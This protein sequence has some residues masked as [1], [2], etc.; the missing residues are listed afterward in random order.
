ME[1][2]VVIVG[3]LLIATPILA[4]FAFVRLQHLAEQ[5]ERA[6]LRELVARV[7]ALEQRLAALQHLAPAA[8]G[9]T[10]PAAPS[11]ATPGVPVTP[12]PPTPERPAVIPSPPPPPPTPPSNAAQE[13]PKP[14]D[15]AHPISL[16][17]AN[18]LPPS[19]PPSGKAPSLDLESLIAGRWFNR[20]GILTLIIAVSFFLKYA[21]DNNWIGS[22]GRVAIGVLLGAAM[23][24]WSHWLFGKGYSYFSE[25][26]AALGQATLLLSI[27]AGCRYYTLFS[28]NVGFAGMIVVTAIMAA[29]A[30]GRNSQRIA[31]LSLLGGFLTPL[32]LSTG[33][34]EETTLFTYLLI[35]GAGLLIIAMRRDWRSLAPV[36]FIFT[37]IYF[38]GWYETY[39]RTDALERTIVFS[40]LFFLLYLAVPVLRAIRT[41]SLDSISVFVVL[42]NSFAYLGALYAMLWPQDRWPLTLV[43]LAL[44][45]GHVA[46]A[47]FA[48]SPR[49]GEWPMTRQL[50]AG[51]A[52]TF[53]TLAIPI[54]L[55]GKW[56]TLALAVEGAIL[57]WTGARSLATLLRG[58][59]FF[60]LALA[61]L[62]VLFL[63][64][65]AP[66][67][68]LNERFGTYLVVIAC[69]G[70]ALAVA[71]EHRTS[72]TDLEKGTVGVFAVAINIYALLALSLELW[73]YFG[74]VASLG[75]D[76]GLAQH[77]G[78]SLLW[79]A[80]AS[81]LILT[82]MKQ[83][84][85]SLRWQALI[86]FGLV[87]L[88]VFL[89]DSS[90]LE[91]FYR[92]L[93][94]L[95]LGLV[96]LVVSFLYQ[97]KVS[98]ERSL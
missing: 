36:S 9:P 42:L 78:L 49:P 40:T 8:P 65:P 85:S 7:Y 11:L 5:I 32:L 94:F 95:V 72:L 44:S 16:S 81:V 25:G 87:V 15:V 74:R 88:K 98:K 61:A 84:V 53:V 39:Y 86:L 58:A 37:Q 3:L 12:P 89:Y 75:I 57:I 18:A 6:R 92:I 51:L 24:P 97:S 73:D 47:R 60:L 41:S 14:H 13:P 26:I 82:G 20:I 77:L 46:V 67:F 91:R 33:R 27:W 21:F 45:A 66:Q 23:L 54:R 10:A 34:N 30:L 2:L 93:S 17:H 50:F 31:L 22:S 55:E 56:I 19:G 90:Y 68:L 4:I 48:P 29:V 52:L 59:G 28:L 79:T 80:Y 43:V 62:R 1:F 69:M 83:Q 70:V 38:W 96:L 64:L 71:Q 76:T 35:L 63:P